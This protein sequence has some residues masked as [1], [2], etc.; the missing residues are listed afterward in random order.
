MVEL[1]DTYALG[2]YALGCEGS[3]PSLGTWFLKVTVLFFKIGGLK[4]G[5]AFLNVKAC[6]SIMYRG[7]E[8]TRAMKNEIESGLKK[9]TK[10]EIN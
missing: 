7:K 6:F 3:N 9:G 4:M 5:K 8:E 10:I 2:A 1:A